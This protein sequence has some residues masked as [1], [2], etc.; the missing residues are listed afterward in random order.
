MHFSAE[1]GEI[2]SHTFDEDSHG[3]YQSDTQS[4]E[5]DSPSTN[6][7]KNLSRKTAKTAATT[8]SSDSGFH[9]AASPRDAETS[10]VVPLAPGE[11]PDHGLMDSKASRRDQMEECVRFALQKLEAEAVGDGKESQREQ[12][13]ECV[14]SALQKF[15]AKALGDSKASQREEMQECVRSA[16]QKIETQ[17]VADSKASQREEMEEC[18]RAALQKFESEAVAD[19]EAVNGDQRSALR[20]F[21]AEAVVFA[22]VPGAVASTET[23][24]GAHA[25][26]GPAPPELQKLE[27]KAILGLPSVGSLEAKYSGVGAHA[28]S[29]RVPPELQKLEN[30]FSVGAVTVGA[31]AVSHG[32]PELEILE[33]K[34]NISAFP[35]AEHGPAIPQQQKLDIESNGGDNAD[36]GR[37]ELQQLESKSL[38]QSH[39]TVQRAELDILEQE[40]LAAHGSA[41]PKWHHK[42]AGS[43]TGS[44]PMIAGSDAESLVTAVRQSLFMTPGAFA[45][46]S[47][48]NN[49]DAPLGANAPEAVDAIGDIEESNHGLVVAEAV[50]H[51]GGGGSATELPT[52]VQM[53]PSTKD[54]RASKNHITVVVAALVCIVVA[55][56]SIAAALL[57][58][59]KNTTVLSATSVPTVSPTTAS[60][61]A[62]T[63]FVVSLPPFTVEALE[64]PES[65]QSIAYR[66]LQEDPMLEEHSE[67]K[68]GQRMAL[69]TFYYATGGYDW[70]VKNSWLSY[71]VDECEWFSK[72]DASAGPTDIF[73]SGS[74]VS[75]TGNESICNDEGFYLQLVLPANGLVGTVPKEIT[76]LRDLHRLELMTNAFSGTLPSE[77]GLMSNLKVFT[78]GSTYS[79][80]LLS[81]GLAGT[82][83]TEMGEMASLQ[84]VE[85]QLTSIAGNIPTEIGNLKKLTMLGKALHVHLCLASTIFSLC[86][87]VVC[88]LL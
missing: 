35:V 1:V 8:A 40:V 78:I 16:L 39:N 49:E 24:V 21:E 18:V 81:L 55:A 88:V 46:G 76:L 72:Y 12:M 5:G 26:A 29:G 63:P 42:A 28:V 86:G 69:A 30:K 60:T 37:N 32:R 82:L 7:S 41:N 3:R 2:S 33:R 10:G 25:V 74:A 57:A 87:S 56:V 75:Q 13:E 54:K 51:C 80:P 50:D 48:L 58:S 71:E 20:K 43:Q 6:S 44:N 45:D 52:A 36:V 17:A 67:M 53:N 77:L 4:R 84:E 68:R 73:L 19:S 9:S 79:S 62:P 83:P 31:V 70:T 34:A 14:R 61:P 27:N 15:E 65:P 11:Q 47:P 22:G 66:W 23:R 64:D 38:R 85:I 59:D